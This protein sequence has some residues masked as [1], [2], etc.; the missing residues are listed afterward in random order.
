MNYMN[1]GSKV[2][3]I[4]KR[5]FNSTPEQVFDAW[6]NPEM[7][8]KWMFPNGKIVRAEIDARIGGTFSFV[9]LRNGEELDHTGEY[10]E[11]DRP[12]RL[13]FTWGVPQASPD[14]ARVIIEIVP[15]ETGSELTLTHELHPNWADFKS[16]IENSWSMMLDAL[17]EAL[18]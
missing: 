17:N 3:A 14:F 7:V 16:K 12:R 6:L 13:V 9:D 4:V 2:N 8:M 1:I 18:K 15:I 5:R 11:I 10:L